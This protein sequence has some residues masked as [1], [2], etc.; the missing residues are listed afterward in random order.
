MED[1]KP[2]KKVKKFHRSKKHA[3]QT[4]E[5]AVV[6][7]PQPAP[8]PEPEPAPEQP[9]D[10]TPIEAPEEAQTAPAPEQQAA[11]PKKT[12][13]KPPVRQKSSNDATVAIVIAILVAVILCGIGYYAYTQSQD[14]P[15]EDEN[16]LTYQPDDSK[17]IA[18]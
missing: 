14:G 3:P 9:D 11:H 1:I 2:P 13:R 7:S 4:V 6:P 8:M 16:N 10:G 5:P 17:Y 12:K 18:C 15:N